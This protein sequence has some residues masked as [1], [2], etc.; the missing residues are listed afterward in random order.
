MVKIKKIYI[1]DIKNFVNQK[2]QIS[3]WLFNLRSSGKILFP[4]IRDGSGYLETIYLKNSENESKFDDLSK[5][6]QESSLTVRGKVKKH[7]NIV[8]I[9]TLTELVETVAKVARICKLPG[10][11]PQAAFNCQNKNISSLIWSEKKISTP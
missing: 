5:L 8:G 3:G 1:K 10:V 11:D 6:S 9:F 2:I 7:F 4:I